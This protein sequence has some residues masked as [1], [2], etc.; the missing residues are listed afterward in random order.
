MA[1]GL[2]LTVPIISTG[3]HTY[4]TEAKTEEETSITPTGYADGVS[5]FSYLYCNGTLYVY[6]N[7]YKK[8]LDKE[9]LLMGTVQKNDYLDYPDEEYESN[10]L[11]IGTEIYASPLSDEY[12]YAKREDG[13]YV[14]FEKTGVP[15][16]VN[17]EEQ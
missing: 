5:C 7:Y 17:L 9:Y 13:V 8:E 2:C 16:A 6:R 3:E 11:A 14:G 15:T 1:I 10:Q 4:S 12:I